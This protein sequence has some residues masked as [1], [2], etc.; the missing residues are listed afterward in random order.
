MDTVQATVVTPV[1]V[2]PINTNINPEEDLRKT[3]QDTAQAVKET[4]NS[5]SDKV[6][7][8]NETTKA[9]GF[10]NQFMNY[11]NSDIFKRNINDT[12]KKYNIPPKKLAQNF[13]ERALGTVS[14]VLG[15]AI[16]TVG[17]A[18]HTLVDILSSIA[19]GAVNLIVN[20]ANALANMVTL[21]KT[22]IA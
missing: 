9:K 4:L 5:F 22:C 6:P 13:F 15:I 19:H 3:M 17:N 11:I 8:D 21:N 1:S 20:V 18:G 2:T 14:D 12:A 16:G 10:L 7:T